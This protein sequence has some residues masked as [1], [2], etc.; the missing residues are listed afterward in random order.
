MSPTNHIYYVKITP[1]QGEEVIESF[2]ELATA[3]FYVNSL[4]KSHFSKMKI[5]R[6]N[7]HMWYASEGMN[8]WKIELLERMIKKDEE[9]FDSSA[10]PYQLILTP[11]DK[12][13]PQEISTYATLT[14]ARDYLFHFYKEQLASKRLVEVSDNK[15]VALPVS[16]DNSAEAIRKGDWLYKI[17]IRNPEQNYIA[18]DHCVDVQSLDKVL[19]KHFEFEDRESA[20]RY[21]QHFTQAKK[22]QIERHH[23]DIIHLTKRGMSQ[24]PEE[25]REKIRTGEQ[26]WIYQIVRYTKTK[27]TNPSSRAYSPNKQYYSVNVF[28]IEGK[29]VFQELL[30]QDSHIQHFIERTFDNEFFNLRFVYQGDDHI[31]LG[32]D[33]PIY[34]NERFIEEKRYTY[35]IIIVPVRATLPVIKETEKT[36]PVSK[37]EKE[38]LHILSVPKKKKRVNKKDKNPS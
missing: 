28:N 22:A 12:S 14:I 16:C 9:Y 21:F 4:L 18:F 38:H 19:S 15:W 37:K 3:R 36:A 26:G 25:A 20:L 29:L 32:E 5:V 11:K 6:A 10:Q 7:K 24:V 34:S 27:K 23:N 2:D 31:F 8:S 33:I 1:K 13:A 30:A 35:E 17:E